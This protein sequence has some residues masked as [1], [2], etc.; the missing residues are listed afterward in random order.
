M[1]THG[2]SGLSRALLG[3][4]ATST[5]RQTD[6]PIVLVRPAEPEQAPEMLPEIEPAS[7]TAPEVAEATV[8]FSVSADEL[9][10]L[11]SIVGERFFNMPIDPSSAQPIRCLLD[12]LRAARA[13]SGAS[14]SQRTGAPA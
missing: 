4:V 7:A 13:E 3:S 14:A 10:L 2:R 11:T 9:D 6:V 1:A 5:L 8:A 12:K